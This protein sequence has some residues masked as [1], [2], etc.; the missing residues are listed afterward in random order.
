MNLWKFAWLCIVIT[1]LLAYNYPCQGINM[2]GN[3][4]ISFTLFFS[5]F[6]Y[7][8]VMDL[9]KWKGRKPHVQKRRK[10]SSRTQTESVW[11]GNG[12]Y[13]TRIAA[14]QLVNNFKVSSLRRNKRQPWNQ[15]G[16]NP[17][18]L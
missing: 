10:V 8:N 5:I 17:S 11:L 18:V 3:N 4:A 14:S 2:K 13:V 16:A 9:I 6:S 7:L 15:K 1:W 12:K